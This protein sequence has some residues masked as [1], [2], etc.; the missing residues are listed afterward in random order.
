MKRTKLAR[1]ATAGL[2]GL[3]VLAGSMAYASSGSDAKSAEELKQFL[4]ANPE[5]AAV[6]AEVESKTGG[7]V[8]EAEFDDDA[9]ANSVV[10]FEIL[11]ADGTEQEVYY[12]LADGTMTVEADDEK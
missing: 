3:S 1:T 10:E 5:V 12:T 6:L 2:L 8:T 11:M 7:K 9:P 4:T